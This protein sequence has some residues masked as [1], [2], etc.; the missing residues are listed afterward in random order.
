MQ[1]KWFISVYKMSYIFTLLLIIYSLNKTYD[2]EKGRCVI[3]LGTERKKGK[4]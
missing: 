2:G 3:Y 1:I 4:E